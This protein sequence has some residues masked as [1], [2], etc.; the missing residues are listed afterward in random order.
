[1][2]LTERRVSTFRTNDGDTSGL[3]T[4]T[5]AAEWTETATA[6]PGAIASVSK[7]LVA[8][9]AHYIT[10]VHASFDAAHIDLLMIDADGTINRH[11]VHNQRSLV[12]EAPLKVTDATA[13]VA[14][15]N[16]TSFNGDISMHGYT[17]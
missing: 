13:A 4:A 11:Q 1:V 10:A 5:Q 9:K 3:A 14:S 7:A 16:V 17:A 8:G 15:L 12:F 6:A 2:A